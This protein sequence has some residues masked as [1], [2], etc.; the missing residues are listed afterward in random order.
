MDNQIAKLN[1]SVM[2]NLSLSSKELFHSNFLAFLFSRDNTLFCEILGVDAFEFDVK[3][4]HK[5][6]DIEIIGK[7]KKYLIENKVKDIIEN[8]QIE[9][10]EKSC[11]KGEYEQFVLFS[12]LGNNLEM[13]GQEHPLWKEIGYEKIIEILRKRNF[14]D[15]YITS[16]KDDYCDFMSAM[17]SLLK[18]QYA[19]CD[20]YTLFRKGNAVFQQFEEIRLHDLLIKY[21]MSHF[22]NFFRKTNSDKDLQSGCMINHAKAT[23][24]FYKKFE[25]IIYGIEI[26]DLDYRRF[27]VA[28]EQYLEIFESLKWFDKNWQSKTGKKYLS[29]SYDKGN[30][31]FWYPNG[32]KDTGDLRFWYQNGFQDRNIKEIGYN[33]LYT[34]ITND[35][36]II[37]QNS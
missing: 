25:G 31:K 27:I 20:K 34:F 10:I 22:L 17:I 29:Y 37:D 36:K 7:Q 4:E 14:Q 24:Y 8:D 30:S 12:L 5:N 15:Q 6:I 16:I 11:K 1:N 3:R 2:F 19:N 35:I 21:G 33:G 28:T 32:F 9:K 23:M 13:T 26:E 18:A